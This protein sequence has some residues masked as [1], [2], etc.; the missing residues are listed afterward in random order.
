MKKSVKC[1]MIG[2]YFLVLVIFLFIYLAIQHQ[3]ERK[4]REL[5]KE[6]QLAVMNQT[7]LAVDEQVESVRKMCLAIA[8]EPYVQ[9]FPFVGKELSIYERESATK[10]IQNIRK[11]Y[12]DN[13]FIEDVYLFYENSGRIANANG[14]YREEEFYVME[15]SYDEPKVQEL[16]EELLR[17]KGSFFLPPARMNNGSRKTE[18]ITFFYEIS[19]GQGAR[20]GKSAKLVVL[21][22]KEWMDERIAPVSEYGKI[23]IRSAENGEELYSFCGDYFPEGEKRPYLLTRMDAKKSG[24]VYESMIP[25]TMIADQMKEAVSP[26]ALGLFFYLLIGTPACFFLAV[27]N[28]KPIRQLTAHMEAIGF[29]REEKGGNEVEYIRSGILQL[30]QKYE[31]LEAKYDSTRQEFDA[32]SRKLM[33]NR[34]RLQEGILLQLIGGYWRDKQEMEERLQGLGVGFPYPYFC[35]AVVQIEEMTEKAEVKEMAAETDRMAAEGMAAEADRMAA[36]GMAAGVGGLDRVFSTE[37]T[38]LRLFVLKN[39]A[40]EFLAPM[41]V[42]YPVSA[43]AEQIYLVLN[44]KGTAG[45]IL[46]EEERLLR[47]MME[48]FRREL[49]LTISIG[50]GE[51]CGELWQLNVSFRKARQA[52]AYGFILGKPSL[53]IDEGI[54]KGEK[55][56]FLYDGNFEKQLLGRLLQKDEQGCRGL[57]DDFYEEAVRQRISVEEGKGLHMLLADMAMKAIEK[58]HVRREAAEECQD[59]VAGILNSRTLPEVFPAL[60]ELF[61]LLCNQKKEED[62]EQEFENQILG[63][64]RE[65]YRDSAFSLAM[66]AEH[67]GISPEHLS[68]TI[69][70]LT[71]RNFIDIVNGF[72]LEQAKRYLLETEK[73][74]EEIAE[75]SGY[76]TAKSFFRSFKQAEGVPPGVWRKAQKKGMG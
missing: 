56:S 44:L 21:L 8:Q 2:S 27:W 61:A 60:K 33:K 32:A 22:K 28:Y 46:P 16:G 54:R 67:F 18:N 74:M 13:P 3:T 14:F 24:W 15:W 51:V 23:I 71:G 66:C 11:H 57:L 40:Q 50:V 20:E 70:Q 35:I 42:V 19:H 63:V 36:E 55:S 31:E 9:Y 41:G 69:K 1:W 48:Y 64:I 65:N 26:M 76:G 17:A 52:L 30:H 10:L 39:V 6:R 4:I 25:Y 72:R 45:A 12:T 37:E 7:M 59:R 75:L 68:R 73:K 62:K 29:T 47:E 43:G 38:E 34:V 5:Y 53:I 49:Q 58:S